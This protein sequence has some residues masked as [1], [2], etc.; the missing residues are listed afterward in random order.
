MRQRQRI[1]WKSKIIGSHTLNVLDFFSFMVG[2]MKGDGGGGAAI[3]HSP[4]KQVWKGE[5]NG[6]SEVRQS[7]NLDKMTNYMWLTI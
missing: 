7:H 3:G 2:E 6:G 4:K 5:E 1:L